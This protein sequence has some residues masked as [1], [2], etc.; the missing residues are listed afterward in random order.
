[1]KAT[2]IY[3]KELRTSGNYNNK[4]VGIELEVS[5]GEKAE[6]VFRKAKL[7]VQAC[8]A[9]TNISPVMLEEMVRQVQRAEDAMRGFAD[10]VQETLS[11]DEEIPF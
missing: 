10:K 8:L 9:S 2:K 5:D 3:Y 4:E 1:M 11:L 6:E 7:F